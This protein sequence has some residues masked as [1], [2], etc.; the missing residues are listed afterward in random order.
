MN[1]HKLRFIPCRCIA[2]KN[3]LDVL[4]RV[5]AG[6]MRVEHTGSC[7]D[8]NEK[9][10]ENK[11]CPWGACQGQNNKFCKLYVSETLIVQIIVPAST[12]P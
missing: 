1:F 8:L 7:K 5:I 6:G 2:K 12:A 10:M 9:Q 3:K 4:W 11:N